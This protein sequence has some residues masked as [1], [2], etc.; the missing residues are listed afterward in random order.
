M[1]LLFEQ[2]YGC[3]EEGA[4][5]LTIRPLEIAGKRVES[6]FI[7]YEPNKPQYVSVCGCVWVCVCDVTVCSTLDSFSP[8]KQDPPM[9][10]SNCNLATEW[11]ARKSLLDASAEAKT[12]PLAGA[13]PTS[14]E[15]AVQVIQPQK[16]H[17]ETVR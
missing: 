15:V 1:D 17:S 13:T 3:L 8:L 11:P 2:I 7:G 4:V 9:F 5:L 16:S 14:G 12:T 6:D 10:P